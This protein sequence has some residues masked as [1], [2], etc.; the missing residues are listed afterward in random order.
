MLTVDS[1]DFDFKILIMY[2]PLILTWCNFGN[3]A[4]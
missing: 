1:I 4:I 3:R 2:T